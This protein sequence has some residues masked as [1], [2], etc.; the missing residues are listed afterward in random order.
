[1]SENEKER[2]AEV[3]KRYRLLAGM[4]GEEFGANLVERIQGARAKS[5][6]NISLWERAEQSVP[7]YFAM[8]VYGAYGRDDLRGQWALEVLRI[9]NPLAWGDRPVEVVEVPMLERAIMNMANVEQR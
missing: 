2:M 1:M 3:T 4:T 7:E 9:H 6:Q 5:K 8:L